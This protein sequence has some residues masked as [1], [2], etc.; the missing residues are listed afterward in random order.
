MRGNRTRAA[1]F[2]IVGTSR[3]TAWL[4]SRPEHWPAWLDGYHAGAASAL[5]SDALQAANLRRAYDEGYRAGI[6]AE[7]ASLEQDWSETMA[8]MRGK[9]PKG[10]TVEQAWPLDPGPRTQRTFAR[11]R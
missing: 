10:W 5:H 4:R 8:L 7:R 6:A 3:F 11:Q 9:V 1:L 2:G